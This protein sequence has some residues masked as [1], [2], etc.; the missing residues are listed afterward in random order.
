MYENLEKA[1]R[2]I[3]RVRDS[4]LAGTRTSEACLRDIAL[5]IDLLYQ[6]ERDMNEGGSAWQ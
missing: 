5:A 2:L 4:L 6:V 3:R 1:E